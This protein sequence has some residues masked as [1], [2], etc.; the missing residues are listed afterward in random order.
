[1]GYHITSNI[2]GTVWG[3]KPA[4]I[5]N[6]AFIKIAQDFLKYSGRSLTKTDLI[7]GCYSAID[8]F[9]FHVDTRSQVIRGTN[10][11]HDGEKE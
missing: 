8:E 4:E 6:D 10:T 1:M 7:I 3:D 2:N 5:L 11:P 9:F